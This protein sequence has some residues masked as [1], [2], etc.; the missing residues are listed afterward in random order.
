MPNQNTL[1]GARRPDHDTTEE[2]SDT[3]P[4]PRRVE[5]SERS[6]RALSTSPK[7]SKSQEDNTNRH[8]NTEEG[9]PRPSDTEEGNARPSNTE[10]NP[11]NMEET[12]PQNTVPV[13]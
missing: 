6:E 9:N 5:S 13:P 4:R 1:Q 3:P 2:E 10:G 11:R 12:R 7:P 8:S